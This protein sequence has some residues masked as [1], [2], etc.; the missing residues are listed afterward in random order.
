MPSGLHLAKAPAP[1]PLLVPPS[2]ALPPPPRLLLAYLV[3]LGAVIG[4]VVN[5]IQHY[6]TNP[7]AKTVW[8]GVAGLLQCILVLASGLVFYLTR[9]SGGDSGDYF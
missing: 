4:S 5:L 6:A 1:A 7:L 9:A 8:P 3:S 2:S